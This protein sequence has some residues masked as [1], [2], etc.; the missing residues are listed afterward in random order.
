MGINNAAAKE[1]LGRLATKPIYHLIGNFH[2]FGILFDE[3]VV[4]AIATDDKAQIGIAAFLHGQ[5]FL[6]HIRA[7]AAIRMQI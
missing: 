3:A 6:K 1:P 5:Q 4:I 7:S 2:P